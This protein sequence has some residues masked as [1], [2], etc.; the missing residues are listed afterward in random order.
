MAQPII[1]WVRRDLRLSDNP[2]LV[3]ACA[4]GGPVIPVFICDEVVERHGAAPKWRQGL[5]VEAFARTLEEA[6]SKLILR[7]GD[8]LAQLQALIEDT[9]AAEVHWNRL[10]DPDSR[11]RDEGV[12]AALKDADIKAVSHRG[13][14][15]FEPWTVETGSGS[16][17]KVYTPFWK[18]VRDRDPGDALATP[19]IPAPDSWPASDDIADW[20]LGA[21]MDRGVEV[22]ADHLNVGEGAARARLANFIGHGIDDY[23]DARDNLG[24]TGTSLLSENLTYGE[25]SARACWWAGRRA[26]EDGKQGA[27]TFL[28]EIVWRD[29]AYHLVHHTPRITHANWREDWDAFPWNEDE[30]RAEVK[31]WKQG[32]TGMPIVDAA[33]REMYVTGR[34]HNRARMLVASYLTKHLM[35]HWKIGLDW[36]EDCLVDWDPASNAMGWQWSAGSG[37]DAT[38][39]FRVF[40]PETQAEKFDRHARYRTRWLAELSSQPPQTACSYFEAIPRSWPMSPEDAYPDAPIVSASEGRQRALDAYSNRNF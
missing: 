35:C 39:Y 16:F 5:G 25:I 28:K 40:N 21:A 10:Y 7:R 11:K 14:V 32:R 15:L 8:A 29:F 20:D 18:A 27:E 22:V 12:K 23:A 26:M 37:P 1:Y 19:K 2:A 33:M 3:A 34:M 13:H 24:K 31:A 9:G 36:F 17:Y 4:A 6:G 38:P 30:R